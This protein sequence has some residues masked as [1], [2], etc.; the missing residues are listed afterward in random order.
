MGR[1]GDGANGR[2]GETAIDPDVGRGENPT[3]QGL[4]RGQSYG[5]IRYAAG[6][7]QSVA[8]VGLGA[9]RRVFAA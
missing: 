3:S 5:L 7:R 6:P 4:R 9:A 1:H 2:I 8:A